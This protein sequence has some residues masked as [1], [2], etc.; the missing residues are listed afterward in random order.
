MAI[1]KRIIRTNDT[2]TSVA[3]IDVTSFTLD[4]AKSTVIS[5]TTTALSFN[6]DGSKM[7]V[8]Q[9]AFNTNYVN[10]YNLSTAF[11]PSTNSYVGQVGIAGFNY[12]AFVFHIGNFIFAGGY[13]NGGGIASMH[14]FALNSGS[15]IGSTQTT[16]SGITGFTNG[17]YLTPTGDKFIVVNNAYTPTVQYI[18]S[19][20][21]PFDIQSTITLLGTV[22]LA[23]FSIS[24]TNQTIGQ[25]TIDGSQ[26]VCAMTVSGYPGAACYIAVL[27]C[28]TPFD[29]NT[30]TSRS[31]QTADFNPVVNQPYVA[32]PRPD[33][34][35]VY[36]Y[37]QFSSDIYVFN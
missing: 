14:R 5:G 15:I 3:A 7:W 27:E 33:N 8:I 11:D 37:N 25:F 16:G 36:A 28:S 23:P 9:V 6:D 17:F 12:G 21:T 20:S 24:G 18:Y 30:V 34:L 13:N 31:S 32:Y 4:S 10:E 19:L 29:L 26:F 2:T 1:N 35:E 22:D